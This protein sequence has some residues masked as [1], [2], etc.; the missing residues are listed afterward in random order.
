[1]AHSYSYLFGLP[2]T[3]LR[4]FTVY[5][6]WGRPDMALFLF[7]K[8]MLESKPIKVFND[9]HM[10][11]DFTYIDD[12]VEMVWRLSKLTPA[13]NTSWDGTRPD[14]ASSKAPYR[15]YNLGNNTPVELGRLIDLL[16]K[17]TGVTAI[18]QNMPMQAGDVPATYADIDEMAAV[19]GF[20]PRCRSKPVSSASSRGIATSTRFEA[21]PLVV[22][23]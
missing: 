3:G 2:T 4:F 21:R 13:P 20:R 23:Q 19:T 12:V 22:V 18:R 14:P 5:G 15:I 8:A 9:G 11:R 17:S 6:P 1:M 7:T 16:E 10:R